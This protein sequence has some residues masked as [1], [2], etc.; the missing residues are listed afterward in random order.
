MLRHPSVGWSLKAGEGFTHCYN[1]HDFILHDKML[2]GDYTHYIDT[3][4][5]TFDFDRYG[6]T[7]K[8]PRIPDN[9]PAL[10]MLFLYIINVRKKE[11]AIVGM[12]F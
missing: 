6:S 12:F 1:H 10:A 8:Y 7:R 9:P 2:T 4:T 11:T 5:Y 3:I